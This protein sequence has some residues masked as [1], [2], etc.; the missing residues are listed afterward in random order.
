MPSL[1]EFSLYVLK[2]IFFNFINVFFLFRDY[3]PLEMIVVLY[4]NKP[5]STLLKNALCQVSMV[6]LALWG[7]G[8]F[9]KNVVNVN[10][11]NRYFVIISL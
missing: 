8:F 10:C 6:N 2:K 5:E 7:R 11:V 9:F 1:V 4:L 3:L